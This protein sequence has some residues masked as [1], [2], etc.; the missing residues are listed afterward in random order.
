MPEYKFLF[1]FVSGC[2]MARP[3]GGAL[4]LPPDR[5]LSIPCHALILEKSM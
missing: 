3:S 1:K 5:S 2:D 4:T